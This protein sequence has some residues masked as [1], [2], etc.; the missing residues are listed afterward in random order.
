M[1]EIIVY[2]K[3]SGPEENL[4]HETPPPWK[5]RVYF[6]TTLGVVWFNFPRV[7]FINDEP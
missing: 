3:I 5:I 1:D 4:A 2:N 7:C 6:L